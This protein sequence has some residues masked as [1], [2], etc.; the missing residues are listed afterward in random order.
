MT[1][2]GRRAEQMPGVRR[3]L[4]ETLQREPTRAELAQQL[5]ITEAGVVEIEAAERQPY[6]SGGFRIYDIADRSSQN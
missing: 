1:A 4:R 2:V 3:E 6:R 5:N